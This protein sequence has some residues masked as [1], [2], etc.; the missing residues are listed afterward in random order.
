M[1]TA[2]T[3]KLGILGEVMLLK[4]R[5]SQV[6]GIINLWRRLDDRNIEVDNSL[7]ER[8]EIAAT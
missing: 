4:D 5:V 2:R 3:E 7:I 8:F 6:S 1:Q